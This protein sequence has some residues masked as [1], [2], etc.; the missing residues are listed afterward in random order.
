LEVLYCRLKLEQFVRASLPGLVNPQCFLG[1]SGA[2]I[3]EL[4]DTRCQTE[5]SRGVGHDF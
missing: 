5:R 3:K 4:E 2:K 1:E